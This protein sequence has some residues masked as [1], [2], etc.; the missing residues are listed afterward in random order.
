MQLESLQREVT[1]LK[2]IRAKL[3]TSREAQLQQA[4][5]M[6]MQAIANLSE[7]ASKLVLS[8]NNHL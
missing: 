2:A 5:V 3:Q 4:Q 7:A 6:M 8:F 1:D